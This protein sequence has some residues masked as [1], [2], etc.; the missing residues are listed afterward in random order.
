MSQIFT[1][2]CERQA[3]TQPMYE[4]FMF[5][6]SAPTWRELDTMFMDVHDGEWRDRWVHVQ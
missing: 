6:A 3:D 5:N 4:E 2:K 1:R